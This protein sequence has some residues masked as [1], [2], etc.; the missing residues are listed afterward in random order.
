MYYNC[1]GKW[2]I[3]EP[4]KFVDFIYDPVWKYIPITEI[5][6]EIINTDIFKRLRNIRQMSLAYITFSGATHTRYEHSIGT[7]HVA[8]KIAKKI[9]KL[10][11]YADFIIEGDEKSY[12]TTLQFIRIAALLHDLGHPPFSHTVEWVFQRYPNLYPGGKYSHDIYTSNLIKE[13]S[14]L[15]KLLNHKII[16]YTNI[17]K[18]LVGELKKYKHISILHKLIDGDLDCDKVDYIV[19]DNYHCGLPVNIDIDLI[20]DS[21]VLKETKGKKDSD[22]PVNI[23]I[24]LKLDKINIAENLLN[25]RYQLISTI[26]YDKKNRIANYMLMNAM[27]D[28]LLKCKKNATIDYTKLLANIHEEWTDFDAY[29]KLYGNPRGN[30]KPN[31]IGLQAIQGNIAN[32]ILQV[33]M[34]FL[35]PIIKNNYFLFEKEYPCRIRAENM[36]IKDQKMDLML[37]FS[38]ISPPPLTLSVTYYEN[39]LNLIDGDERKPISSSVLNASNIIK[40]I[41]KDSIQNSFIAVY[42]NTNPK[43]STNQLI[44][45]IYGIIDKE[46][47]DYRKTLCD[48][49]EILPC[50][51]ILLILSALRDFGKEIVEHIRLWATGVVNLQEFAISFIKDIDFKCEK[52]SSIESKYSSYFDVL[53]NKLTFLG[54]IDQR[55]KSTSLPGI[56]LPEEEK[57]RIYFERLDHC[58]NYIGKK[59]IR[60]I[61]TKYLEIKNKLLDRL[62]KNKDLYTDYIVKRDKLPKEERSQFLNSCR[63]KMK[64][65]KLPILSV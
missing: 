60:K 23:A 12:E 61:P 62:I 35:D 47:I 32:E 17:S 37:D 28:F 20:A 57:V 10:K 6:K 21:F 41:L 19:R 26:Q 30:K 25:S 9:E 44:E 1:K 22:F 4:L 59:Y 24:Q 33:K 3:L 53:L 63:N 27:K 18:F 8:Y 13:N 36:L 45:K 52:I 43:I 2:V 46:N 31:N 56:T 5:E 34:K 64:D 50:D 14:E 7:M 58:L 29:C 51:F 40:G 38:F 16:N 48:N 55:V 15:K 49:N 11:R 42:S 65:K 39:R 54:L